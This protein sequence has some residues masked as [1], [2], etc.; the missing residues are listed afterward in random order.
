MK[1]NQKLNQLPNTSIKK[2]LFTIKIFDKKL[3]NKFFDKFRD[4]IELS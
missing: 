2:K 3:M 4:L 1:V